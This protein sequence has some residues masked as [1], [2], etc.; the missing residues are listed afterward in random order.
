MTTPIRL[1]GDPVFYEPLAVAFDKEVEDNDSLVE[2]VD[3]IVGEMHE[4]GTLSGLSDEWYEGIDYTVQ[5]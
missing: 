5:E 4:D 3:A 1:V 2:A